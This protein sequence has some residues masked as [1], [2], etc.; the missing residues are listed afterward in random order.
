MFDNLTPKKSSEMD[1]IVGLPRVA[2]IPD[3][4]VEKFSERVLLPTATWK[5]LNQ[6]QVAALLAYI[7]FG[8]LL[9]AI[10]VGV[11][12]T[13][14][15]FKIADLAYT[16]GLRKMI[17]LIPANTVEKTAYE[18]PELRQEISMNY[19][20][21]V[22]GKQPKKKRQKLS[23]E[24]SGLFIMSYS[25]LS[26]GD[27]DELLENIKPELF[28]TDEA[29]NLANIKTCSAA[30]RIKR[31]MDAKPKTEFCG[32]S[33]T[34]TSKGLHDYAHLSHWALK[35]TSPIPRI[36]SEV[37]EWN[38]ALG[39]TFAQHVFQRCFAPLIK[40]ARSNYPGEDFNS[41][42]VASLR[43]A[44]NYRLSTAPGSI[45]SKGSSATA[46]LLIQNVPVKSPESY[47]GWDKIEQYMHQVQEY[48]MAPDGSEIMY[49]I[50]KFRYMHQLSA[51]IHLELYWPSLDTIRNRRQCDKPLAMELLERSKEHHDAHKKYSSELRKWLQET[52]FSGMDSPMLVGLNMHHY[53]SRDVGEDLY[54]KWKYMKSLE[55]K[56]MLDRDARAHR[57]CDYKI[58]A[59][60]AMAKKL[61]KSCIFWVYHQ[62]MGV[63]L[64]Q[65]M[66]EAGLPV[67]H[68]PAT[69]KGNMYMLDKSNKDMFMV[70]SIHAHGTGKNL[71]HF[72]N[73]YYVQFMRSATQGEQSLGRLHRQGYLWDQCV[74]FTNNTIEWDHQMMAAT[75]A[76]SLY[77]HQSQQK[78]KLIYADY[79]PVPK[80]F[81]PQVLKERGFVA[82]AEE[83]DEV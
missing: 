67:L 60:L 59:A 18:L 66:K 32:M 30:K 71:Q 51:G 11:G 43:K 1:R 41:S 36:W 6:T 75:I 4:I 68:C 34:L 26:L 13:A 57:V 25:Q 29:H 70:A 45:A 31:Y 42:E 35:D 55:F 73:A 16:K 7:R 14:I 69:S 56:E 23:K 49:P 2:D 10:G 20:I 39:T 5:S 19:P 33:G 61:K 21:H 38:E 72:K 24:D 76:D 17:L 44:F 81:S 65:V 9:G 54:I 77:I 40:W 37:D 47:A 52:N 79:E 28:I 63:W 78:Q 22:L 62:E 48:D 27:T 64:Y 46:S 82:N 50:H 53:G 15:S 83:W 3:D 8:G 74:Q 12:K 80:T 58:Q